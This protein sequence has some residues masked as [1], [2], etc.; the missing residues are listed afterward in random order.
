[1]SGVGSGTYASESRKQRRILTL[2]V[3]LLTFFLQVSKELVR[4][5]SPLILPPE[6]GGCD[7]RTMLMLRINQSSR[8]GNVCRSSN[9]TGSMLSHL[10]EVATCWAK[11]QP[12][13][14]P[15]ILSKHPVSAPSSSGGSGG[16]KACRAQNPPTQP[17]LKP[18]G[19]AQPVRRSHPDDME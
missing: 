8:K 3:P 10:A 4:G 13:N 17:S 11:T 14:Y 2:S 16:Q 9:L 19:S 6:S 15:E 7:W 1:M 18:F 5:S 12:V